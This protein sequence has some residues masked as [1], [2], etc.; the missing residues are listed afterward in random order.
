MKGGKEETQANT[1]DIRCPKA[2]RDREIAWLLSSSHLPVLHSP[3]FLLAETTQ[4]PE[5]KG[6]WEM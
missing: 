5:E 3:V 2:K 1:G 6:V 4:K